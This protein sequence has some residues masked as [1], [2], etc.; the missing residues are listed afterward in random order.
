VAADSPRRAVAAVCALDGGTL[1]A[2]RYAPAAGTTKAIEAGAS[3]LADPIGAAVACKAAAAVRV[4]LARAAGVHADRGTDAIDTVFG[5]V[6]TAVCI[7]LA[8]LTFE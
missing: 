3:I 8:R 4:G 6:V 1:I 7:D 5:I 2:L